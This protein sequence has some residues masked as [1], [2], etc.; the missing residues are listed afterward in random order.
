MSF[1]HP[2]RYPFAPRAGK[3]P[4]A[5]SYRPAASASALAM[6]VAGALPASAATLSRQVDVAA[7]PFAVW[8]AIGPFCA[9]A[10]WHPAIASCA[11]DGATP[12]TR[13]LV[14]R[15][16]ATFVELQ[17]A[18]SDVTHSYSYTFTSSPVPVTHYVSTFRVVGKG[19]GLSK[20]VWSGT[21]TPHA[22]MDKQADEALAGIYESGLA[23]IKAKLAR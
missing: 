5:R 18:R 11:L 16:K 14:T 7:T 20:V 6:I 8:S 19:K 1:A 12:P 2:I 23:A 22:G 3:S 10:D 13:T 17:T 4:K 21:Y 9:I 15:D